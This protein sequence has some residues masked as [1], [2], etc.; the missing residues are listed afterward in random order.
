MKP[1]LLIVDDSPEIAEMIGDHLAS[2]GYSVD[3]AETGTEA[4]EFLSRGFEGVVLLDYKLP[5]VDGLELLDRIPELAPDSRV[6]MVTAHASM[7]MAMKAIQEK[8]AFYVHSKAEESF[9]D[10]LTGTVANAFNQLN[11]ELKLRSLEDQIG[12]RYSFASIV[13]QSRE[14]EALFRTLE[15]VVESKVAVLIQGES[16]TGKE[17]I[18]KAIHY[19]SP[20]QKQPF[21]A[22]NC[23]GIPDTLLESELFGY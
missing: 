1:K 15:H 14:M 4:L 18:A 20:R 23:A 13:T 3:V 2:V 17:L 16:G 6:I 7:G 12:S 10:R 22:I 11:L 5:D 19:N 9:I 21:V 8:G